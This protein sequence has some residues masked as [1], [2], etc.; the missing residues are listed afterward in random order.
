MHMPPKAVPPHSDGP[1][2]WRRLRPAA[3]ATGTS[4]A[5]PLAQLPQGTVLVGGAVP[6]GL[7]DRLQNQPDLDLV[8]PTD[9]IALT[10][11]L[12]QELHGTCVVLDEDAALPG[13]CLDAGRSTS[14]DRTVP[15]SKTTSGGATTASMPSLFR[16]SL[17]R[18]W[19]P[20]GGLNDLQ[21]GA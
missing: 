10:Q 19:D 13:W 15:T 9:A 5:L 7:L 20:T 3:N 17:G 18:L 4:V 21:Q 14:P 12:A 8:V 6:D 1:R 16:F 2:L 11:A